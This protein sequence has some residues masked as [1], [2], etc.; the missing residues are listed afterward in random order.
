MTTE[1][2][3]AVMEMHGEAQVKAERAVRRAKLYEERLAATQAM[4]W[5]LSSKLDELA[6]QVA[7]AQSELEW[8]K[9]HGHYDE[10]PANY[11]VVVAVP[12][13]DS[14]APVAYT[15]RTQKRDD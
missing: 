9:R 2:E 10:P 7:E 15:T 1:R 3:F 8:H 5:Q 6:K 13:P 4:M 14:T 11:D 12:Q